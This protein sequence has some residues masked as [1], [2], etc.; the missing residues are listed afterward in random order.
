[1]VDVNPELFLVCRIGGMRCALPLAGVIETLRP[2]AMDTLSGAP[3]FVAGLS[4]IRGDPVPVISGHYL[5]GGP[6]GRTDRWI[7][8]RAGAHRVA[9][10]VDDVIGIEPLLRSELGAMPPLMRRSSVVVAEM[11]ALDGELLLVLDAGRVIPD[12]LF[13]LLAA[14]RVA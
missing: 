7:V 5:L 8:L 2:L 3:A 11:G 14:R 10:G 9:L 6:G 1:M 13:E 12:E 4:I